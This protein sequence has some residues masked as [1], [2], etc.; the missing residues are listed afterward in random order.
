VTTLLNTIVHFIPNLVI[1]LLIVMLGVLA[2]RFVGGLVRAV[3]S[4]GMANPQL[5][6]DLAEWGV[7]ALAPRSTEGPGRTR[8]FFLFCSLIPIWTAWD[9]IPTYGSS[10]YL[11]VSL[12]TGNLL[13]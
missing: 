7:I 6:G 4:S 5:M 13:W 11:M 10:A 8:P 12:R 9:A 3:A 1:P 2:A